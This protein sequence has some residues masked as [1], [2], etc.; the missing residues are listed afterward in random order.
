MQCG[1]VDDAWM[2]VWVH[3]SEAR[4]TATYGQ[5]VRQTGSEG[6]NQVI[7]L[8]LHEKYVRGIKGPVGREGER[9]ELC[10]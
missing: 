4:T 1:S 5:S 6:S 2:N 10:P 3:G 7:T 9:R 8:R